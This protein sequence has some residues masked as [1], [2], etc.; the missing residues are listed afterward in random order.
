MNVTRTASINAKRAC[1]AVFVLGLGAGIL[2]MM[3][4]PIVCAL[5]PDHRTAAMNWPAMSPSI[6]RSRRTATVMHCV[7]ESAKAW[8]INS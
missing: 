5:Q 6:K 7:P 3:L 2:D 4:S 1:V 8:L